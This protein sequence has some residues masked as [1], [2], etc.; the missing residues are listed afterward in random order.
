MGVILFAFFF[1]GLAL[2]FPALIRITLGGIV[3]F[4][5]A[6]Y[7][8]A[9]V[10]WIISEI[11][12]YLILK[13]YNRLDKKYFQHN[14][15][16]RWIFSIKWFYLLLAILFIAFIAWGCYIPESY[17]SSPINNNYVEQQNTNYPDTSEETDLNLWYI[18]GYIDDITKENLKVTQK[19]SP[20]SWCSY[21]WGDWEWHKCDDSLVDDSDYDP[22]DPINFNP[23]RIDNTP[24]AVI[25]E[26]HIPTATIPTAT[27]PTSTTP[28]KTHGYYE[29]DYDDY[30]D[31]I[32][33]DYYWGYDWYDAHYDDWLDEYWE[34]Y[35]A[36]WFDSYDDYYRDYFDRNKADNFEDYYEVYSDYPDYWWDY[37]F[38][39][40]RADFYD[41]H[42]W[43]YFDYDWR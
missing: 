14:K 39:D 7:A 41:D 43:E 11:R 26:A 5:V 19:I 42:Y 4:Y 1:V 34:E 13:P 2:R 16:L 40:F 18:T 38:D 32:W 36:R 31:D 35:E 22:D 8:F 17:K 37:T 25:P 21:I 29:E 33:Y 3:L 12:K 28:K 6:I 30:Y 9:F 24:T 27:I 10:W 20:Y 15:V 23:E